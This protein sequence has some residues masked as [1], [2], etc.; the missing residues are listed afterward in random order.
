MDTAG[1]CWRW[2]WSGPGGR[3]QDDQL[4]GPGREPWP[5]PF[6]T[7]WKQGEAVGLACNLE[8][9]KKEKEGNEKCMW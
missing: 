5:P 7:V 6:H 1:W 2:N 8:K 4:S 9:K 3:E